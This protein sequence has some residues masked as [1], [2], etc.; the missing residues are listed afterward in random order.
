MDLL[1][2]RS[3]RLCRDV[4]RLDALTMT[5]EESQDALE[6]RPGYVFLLP[7]GQNTRSAGTHRN[8]VDLEYSWATCVRH[9]QV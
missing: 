7:T 8:T 1:R 9:E 3:R 2:A 5:V 4:E 6:L